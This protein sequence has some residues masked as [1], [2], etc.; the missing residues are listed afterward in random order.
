M[1][2]PIFGTRFSFPEQS[3]LKKNS[4]EWME[5]VCRSLSLSSLDNDDSDN[6]NTHFDFPFDV[7]YYY[8][9]YRCSIYTSYNEETE[10]I[11]YFVGYVGEFAGNCPRLVDGVVNFFNDATKKY[12][13]EIPYCGTML[14]GTFLVF[15]S[16][17]VDSSSE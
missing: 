14:F 11:E 17:E 16:E 13:D 9:K 12:E 5:N 1:L 7:S 6:T 10:C 2:L 8:P 15:K 4:D 3:T